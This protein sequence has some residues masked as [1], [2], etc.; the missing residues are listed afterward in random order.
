MNN[1]SLHKIFA[2]AFI[3]NFFY[4]W[5]VIYTPIFLH[6]HVGFSLGAIGMIMGIALFPFVLTQAFWGKISDKFWGQKEILTAG[7]LITGLSTI[8][9]GLYDIKNLYFWIAILFMTRIGASM[10]EVMVETYLFKKINEK[11]TDIMSAYRATLPLAYII[12][13]VVASVFLIFFDV[14]NMFILLGVIVIVGIRYSLS[15]KDTM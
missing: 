8:I 15:L 4:T 5:M 1:P 2:C 6:D 11:N 10:I 7:F 13:P 14:P 9:I 3:L 12:S